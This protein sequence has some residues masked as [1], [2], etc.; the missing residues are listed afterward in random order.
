MALYIGF[1]RLLS[2]VVLWGLPDIYHYYCLFYIAYRFRFA[3]SIVCR[4]VGQVAHETRS[5][6]FVINLRGALVVERGAPTTK[7]IAALL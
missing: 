4:K 7:R 3:L 6:E 1:F 5:H 2:R